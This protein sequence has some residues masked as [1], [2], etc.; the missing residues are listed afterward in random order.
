M[1]ATPSLCSRA[2]TRPIHSNGLG[3]HTIA[4][5]SNRP[6]I[7]RFNRTTVCASER[8]GEPQRSAETA[9]LST[10]R[11]VE[12]TVSSY[13]CALDLICIIGSTLMQKPRGLATDGVLVYGI[14]VAGGCRFLGV[15]CGSD[16]AASGDRSIGVS[17]GHA[18][19]VLG[20]W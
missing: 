20:R 3:K 5:S 8:V 12:Q 14:Y 17:G 9:R 16:V 19:R 15:G 4:H 10:R 1:L 11:E 2:T 6:G 7:G 18:P 13:V